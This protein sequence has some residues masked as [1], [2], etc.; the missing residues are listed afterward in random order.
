MVRKPKPWVYHSHFALE[1]GV[2]PEVPLRSK[3]KSFKPERGIPNHGFELTSHMRCPGWHVV[4]PNQSNLLS[5]RSSSIHLLRR[6]D[7]KKQLEEKA[8]ELGAGHGLRVMPYTVV[9]RDGGKPPTFDSA[10]EDVKEASRAVKGLELWLPRATPFPHRMPK[11][12]LKTRL[13]RLNE[14]LEQQ[15][16]LHNRFGVVNPDL[17]I[18][19]NILLYGPHVKRPQLY[20]SDYG[21]AYDK[22]KVEVNERPYS[23]SFSVHSLMKYF[24]PESKR[25]Q[26][27]FWKGAKALFGRNHVSSYGKVSKE[28]GRQLEDILKRNKVV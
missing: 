2:I 3:L 23:F 12:R 20:F 1:A 9:M 18:A 6:L 10:I 5:P 7:V 14:A 26:P 16:I 28:V 17:G 11:A 25:A 15:D 24:M 13:K 27:E 4:L 8:K 21:Q 19:G 22:A